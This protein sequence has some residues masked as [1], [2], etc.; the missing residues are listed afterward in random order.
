MRSDPEMP[1]WKRLAGRVLDLFYPPLCA[2]CGVN[3]RHGRSLCTACDEGLPRLAAPFCQ[4]CGEMFPG[5]IGV[6]FSC[7]NCK[8]LRFSFDFARPATCRDAHTL[9]LIH[10]LKYGREIHLARELGR[11]AH[12]A[13]ADDPRLAPA[14]EGKWPLVPVPLHRKRM[15]HRHFNQAAEISRALAIHAGLPVLHALRRTRQTETQTRLSRKQR[16]ENLRGAFEITRHGRRWIETSPQGAV[17]V[18]DV[19]TTGST[20]NECAKTLRRA[21]FHSVFVVTVM[22]G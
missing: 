7:P 22:R 19:L 3:L 2:L 6:S 20:V 15:Q 10:R 21:G 4:S 18:D 11:L 8:D 5:I 1:R 14:L 12:G 17:L 13:F 16:M 9:D